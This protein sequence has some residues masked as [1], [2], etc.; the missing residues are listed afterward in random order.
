MAKPNPNTHTPPYP[1]DFKSDQVRK[2]ED[3]TSYHEEHEKQIANLDNK[4]GP[5]KGGR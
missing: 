1:A 3:S 4:S 2:R 5:E